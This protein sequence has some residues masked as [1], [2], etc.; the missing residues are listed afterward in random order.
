VIPS[1]INMPLDPVLQIGPI[2]VHWYGLGYA[3]AFYVGYRLILPFAVSRGISEKTISDAFWW[4]IGI[5]LVAARLYFV[6]QQPNL[7]IYF[8]NPLKIIAVWEGGMAFFGAV[9]ACPIALLVMSYRWKLPVWVVLDGAALFATLPQAIGRVG[10]IINGDILGP[11]STLPWA[12]R[13][14]SPH[15]FAP[16]G[17]IAYQPAGAYEL[18]VSLAL[19]AVVMV[20]VR[21][22]APDGIAWIVYLSGYAIS[23]FLLFFV[24]ATEPV[25]F[26]GLKQAQVTALVI[27]LLVVPAFILLRLRYPTIFTDGATST[28]P[29]P[30]RNVAGELAQEGG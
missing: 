24:R 7:S 26:L 29:E 10:N 22:R 6:I 15:T 17:D 16:R 28:S 1:I 25:V 21:R 27:L 2:P 9:I 5:G 23:Q 3:I 14:T 13:Y 12:V 18:L 19:F 11:P 20:L 30:Q 8:Q 4:N